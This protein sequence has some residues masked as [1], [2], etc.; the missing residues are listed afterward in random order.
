MTYSFKQFAQNGRICMQGTIR[1]GHPTEQSPERTGTPRGFHAVTPGLS[2]RLLD[3]VPDR[4]GRI[5]VDYLIDLFAV[6]DHHEVQV[7]GTLTRGAVDHSR[8]GAIRVDAIGPRAWGPLDQG[9]DAVEDYVIYLRDI[10]IAVEV[11][12]G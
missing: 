3:S 6:I 1:A 4:C 9:R 11:R 7:H 5:R 8:S 12:H 10:S 2:V